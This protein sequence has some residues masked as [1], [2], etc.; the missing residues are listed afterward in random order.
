MIYDGELYRND[1]NKVSYLLNTYQDYLDT[2]EQ[3][4]DM[5][6]GT[7]GGAGETALFGD[8]GVKGITKGNAIEH[9]LTYL[10]ANISDTIAFGDAKIDIPMLEYCKI[11]VAMGSG[12]TEIKQ[13]ADFVTDDVDKDGLYNAFVKLGLCP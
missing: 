13:A 4:P 5:A 7:W 1:L 6:K 10:N 11:G 2:R 9:L 12:G 8:I 3:F